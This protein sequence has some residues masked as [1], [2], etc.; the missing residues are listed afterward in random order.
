MGERPVGILGTGSRLPDNEVGNAEI[1]ARVGVTEQW[2]EERTGIRARRFVAADEATSDLAAGAGERA[3]KAAGVAAGDIDF[4]IVSTSTPDSPQPPTAYHVQ[5]RLGAWGAV[6]FDVNVV[7]S[8]FV[9]ALSIARS[10]IAQR[11]GSRALV[12]GAD[13]YSRILDFSDRRTAVL[14]SDGAG[15]AVLGEVGAPY[16]FVDFELASR[17]DAHGLIRV[18]AGGSRLP[19]SR[20]TVAEGGHHFRMDGRGVRN[21]VLEQLP[22]FLDGLYRRAGVGREQIDHFVPHQPNGVMLTQIVERCGLSAARTH[23]TL[24]RYGNPGTA[25]VAV[26]LD[27]ACRQGHFHDGDL[28]LI[29]GFG[30]GMSMGAALIRWG[31]TA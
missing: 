22:G 20:R 21:F 30:G 29:A 7:C 27:A 3:L 6:C 15:A 1:A 24:E 9:Y 8:G 4:L 17:G 2:I 10:L 12:V 13:V 26:T 18:E 14:M 23:R 5:R 25:A 16:G 28:V 31:V 19:A 11:P